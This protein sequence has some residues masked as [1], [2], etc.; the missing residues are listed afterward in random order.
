MKHALW[1]LLCVAV[2]GQA[3]ALSLENHGKDYSENDPYDAEVAAA[4]TA[5]L[6]KIFEQELVYG[7][8]RLSLQRYKNRESSRYNDYYVTIRGTEE[9]EATIIADP[10]ASPTYIDGGRL[11]KNKYLPVHQALT[12]AGDELKLTLTEF[13]QYDRSKTD[14]ENYL[15]LVTLNFDLYGGGNNLKVL[16]YIKRTL[17]LTMNTNSGE[18]KSMTVQDK[19]YRRVLFGHLRT[20]QKTL[21]NCD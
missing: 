10:E 7:N 18:V 17:Q 12:V 20:K 13:K 1:L 16:G 5:E 21:V 4:M 2:G 11:R 15:D 8:C 9:E 19:F 14:L 6:E 3:S